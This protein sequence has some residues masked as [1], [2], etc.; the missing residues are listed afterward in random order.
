MIRHGWAYFED[1]PFQERFLRLDG[2]EIHYVDEGYGGRT[3]LMVHGNPAW[4]YIWRRLIPR[5]SAEYRVLAFDLIGF[6]KSD[7][8]HPGLHDFPH[9]ARIVSG[10]IESLGLRNITL[11]AH[12]W[13][14]TFAMQYVVRHPANVSGLVLMNTFLT[15]DFRIP[16]AAAAKIS[17]ATIKSSCLHPENISDSAM[18]AYWSPFP[19][20]DAKKSYQAFARMF[21]DSLTH[22]SYKPMKEIEQAL[23]NLKIPTSIIW[24]TAHGGAAYAEKLAKTIPGAK[25]HP[26]NAGHF[27]QEDTP[28]EVEKLVI[29]SLDGTAIAGLENE[30][31]PSSSSKPGRV[32]LES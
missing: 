18:E 9:H 31:N 10:F 2:L 6:G 23:P 19:D 4:S 28:A 17:P 20:D 16:R 22:P 24:G 14:A 12:D 8:P 1:Y 7:K 15:T 25:L 21:P 32:D 13:G 3:V 29:D 11:V 27:V 30:L 26:V 5:V